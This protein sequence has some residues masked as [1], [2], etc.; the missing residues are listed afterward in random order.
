MYLQ[1]LYT[2]PFVL[3]IT[4][5]NYHTEKLIVTLEKQKQRNQVGVRL[6][7]KHRVIGR[8]MQV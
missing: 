7:G 2:I 8:Y 5:F 3:P 1:H 6:V 4:L